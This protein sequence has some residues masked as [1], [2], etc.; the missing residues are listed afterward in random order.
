MFY[1]LLGDRAHD[2]A[3]RRREAVPRAGWA[4]PWG[5]PR[6]LAAFTWLYIVWSLVPVVIAIAVLVQRG[7]LANDLAGLLVPLV[8]WGDPDQS[9]STTR[10]C[11][12]RSSTA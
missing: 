11:G 4:N 7:P 9:C 3:G 12:A 5:K 2:A 1:Y 10:P 6:F 8:H